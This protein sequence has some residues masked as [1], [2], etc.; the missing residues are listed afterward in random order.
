MVLLDVHRV[1]FEPG[2]D[3]GLEHGRAGW[4]LGGRLRIAPYRV[5]RTTLSTYVVYGSRRHMVEEGREDTNAPQSSTL[6]ITTPYASPSMVAFL[7]VL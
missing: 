3:E 6:D 2:G 4:A 1:R 7:V 5:L